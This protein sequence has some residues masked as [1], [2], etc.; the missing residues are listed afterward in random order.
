MDLTLF[1][2][3][4]CFLMTKLIAFIIICFLPINVVFA[5]EGQC[6]FEEV[7]KDT[8]TQNGI[9]L[10]SDSDMRYE[11]FDPILFT[12]I[13][14]NNNF[15]LIPNNNRSAFEAIKDDRTKVFSNFVKILQ[16]YPHIDRQLFLDDMAIE[17]EKS[18]TDNYPKRIIIKSNR[19][20][21]SIHLYDCQSKPINKLFFKYNPIFDYPR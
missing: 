11:Y 5:T 13:H 10:I 7:Y 2:W 3:G 6:F 20:N 21:L 8:S 9:F 19:V 12:I 18:L 15:F 4:H 16:N 17:I 1:V 14:T